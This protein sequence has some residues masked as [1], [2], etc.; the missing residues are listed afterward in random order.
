MRMS[1]LSAVTA[2]TDGK[3]DIF[4]RR[5]WTRKCPEMESS[6]GWLCLRVPP[7]HMYGPASGSLHLRST[8]DGIEGL[9]GT[10]RGI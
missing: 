3:V 1:N 6:W 10:S 5:L 2:F 9:K 4:G 7:V 8:E